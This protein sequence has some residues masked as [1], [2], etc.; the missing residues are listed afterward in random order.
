[1]KGKILLTIFLVCSAVLLRAQDPVP[2]LIVSEIY[3]YHTEE[4]YV[5][6][7]N[8]GD[9]PVDLKR[10]IF[11]AS[12]NGEGFRT[13]TSRW[14]VQFLSSAPI[15]DPGE[16]FVVINYRTS[17]SDS[18]NIFTPS[19]YLEMADYMLM[20]TKRGSTSGMRFSNGNDAF[21]L[22]WDYDGDFIFDMAIDTLIDVVGFENESITFDVA[23]VTNASLTHTFIRKANISKGNAGDWV[24]SAGISSEDSEW[25]AIPYDPWRLGAMFTTVGNHG[26]TYPWDFSPISGSIDGDVLSMAWGAVR[27]SIFKDIS[28]GENM[29]WNLR[30]G[31]DT[32]FSNAVQTK[33]T[34]FVYLAGDEGETRKYPITITD[35]LESNNII[36]PKLT[37]NDAG[38]YSSPYFVTDGVLGMDTVYSIPYGTRSDTLFTYL[39]KAAN[40]TW[41]LQ[42]FD[43]A[44]RA[45]VISGDKLVVTAANGDKKEYYILTDEYS[46]SDNAYLETILINNDTLWGF[47]RNTVD[48]QL[49]L[50]ANVNSF[51]SISATTENNDARASITQP[52]FI[53]GTEAERTAIISVV[54]E[55]DTISLDYRI[56]FDVSRTIQRNPLEPFYSQ[57]IAG[58]S[59]GE[60][61]FEIFNPGNVP[62]T[63]AD[64]M[65]IRTKPTAGPQFA[66]LEDAL[67]TRDSSDHDYM[68]NFGFYFDNSRA[69]QGMYF[70]EATNYN[71][72]IEPY[73]VWFIKRG[74]T[75]HWGG[76]DNADFYCLKSDQPD[77]YDSNDGSNVGYWYS[78]YSYW[79][80][81]M[82]NDSILLGYKSAHEVDDWKF[83][84]IWG[85]VGDDFDHS[86]TIDGIPLDY[87]QDQHYI[88]KGEISKGNPEPYGSIKENEG[89][90]S[91]EWYIIDGED[92]TGP[93][94]DVGRH[95]GFIKPTN[96]IS[97]V[98][99]VTYLV[100]TGTGD[101][102]S[103]KGVFP[104]STV[105]SFYE[106]I[107]KADPGQ[108]LKV[109]ASSGSGELGPSDAVQ[110]G[111]TLV[112]H[113]ED[114]SNTTK[115]VIT[116]GFL[117]TN[118]ILSS[119]IYDIGLAGLTG[120]I[121]TVA[122]LTTINELLDHL[123]LPNGAF[124][125]IF[126]NQRRH[127]PLMHM[128]PDTSIAIDPVVSDSIFV[129]VIAEDGVTKI[130]YSL[131]MA[132]NT[133]PYL[134]SNVYLLYQDLKVV[135]LFV[136][137][138]N[139]NT[140][141][142]NVTPSSGAHIK[143]YDKYEFERLH[144]NMYIDDKVVVTDQ[145]AES[146]TY[147]L[148]GFNDDN[149]V[150]ETG[151]EPRI[152]DTDLDRTHTLY[153]NPAKDILNID[154]L[155]SGSK[156]A[157]INMLGAVLEIREAYSRK[158]ELD[159]SGYSA[160]V[161]FI[162][163][164]KDQKSVTYSFIKQ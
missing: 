89:P 30:W 88:R 113:A 52:T 152:G 120:T 49:T 94:N 53:R 18:T 112:V 7:T 22:F 80:L 36:I 67:S 19:W 73:S 29:G 136:D 46:P 156:I 144:G 121:S 43:G 102:E 57:V 117:S 54:S 146:V 106:K 128:A 103:V 3:M 38:E 84:D 21:G 154:G 2:Q 79:L 77:F 64:Y 71:I 150:G 41:A 74:N 8:M 11:S 40:A 9:A 115:Y 104:G 147:T 82:E 153:P 119:D 33:D 90:G 133:E 107:I 26:N 65:M 16:S 35:P 14:N 101:K 32:I 5:E 17:S 86:I 134:T 4:A 87:D 61:G 162:R 110:A 157:V 44:T 116:T 148:H 105:S 151:V 137:N 39:E 140:F 111:D 51:P 96:F 60:S 125:N 75:G 142:H 20:Y 72:D 85:T 118:A 139:I 161:Y 93:L 48:Y 12:Q 58:N 68:L 95:A 98:T 59:S 159:L 25:I 114:M 24:N 13:D 47:S 132:V 108:I 45:E 78:K 127:V 37:R 123:T 56:I 158:T 97:T 109:V 143:I 155:E 69:D 126:D 149:P 34:L 55:S 131:V 92:W 124:M 129:E 130:V 28:V 50:S 1:M 100:S 91:S 42:T 163:V 135:D 66:S 31:P 27:D 62:L 160:G 70:K 23:G 63:L 15:L 164:I 122:H 10:V 6:L 81:K 99:S 138:T 83:V 76:P 145:N 141:M